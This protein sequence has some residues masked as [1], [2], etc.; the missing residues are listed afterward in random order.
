MAAIGAHARFN[1]FAFTTGGAVVRNQMFLRFAGEGT[2]ASI[3]GATLLQAAASTSTRRSSPITRLPDCS[4]REV[5]KTV[6]DDE[7]RG[8]FQ[9]KIIVRP[10]AQKTDAKMVTQA[11]LLSED[12]EADNKPE[13]EIFADDVQCG[14]GA[15]AG[16]LDEDLLFYLMARGIPEKEAEALLIQA[17]IGEAIEGI[18]HAGLREALMDSAAQWLAERE[19]DA[20]IRQSATALTTSSASARI[21]RSWRC[22][23]TASRWSISTTPP[24]R[25]SRRRCST[26]CMQAYTS[27]YANVHRGLHYLANAA[28]EGLR[29]RAREGA[30]LP[31]RARPE[32]IIFTRNATEAINLVAYTFGA[33][34]HQGGRRDRA[35]DHGAPFQ[36]R[37][38]AFPARAPRRRDQVG[39]GRRRRQFPARRIREAADRRAP[40][41][42][43][44][45]RCRTRSAPIVPV[46]E[47]TRIAHARGIPVLVD[48]AQGAV[49]LDVDVQD[50]DCDFYVITGHKLYGP[51]GIGVLYGK[52]DASRRDAAV[53]RRRRDDP[54]SVRRIASPTASRRTGSRPARRRSC[55]RSGSAP[56]STTCSRSARRAS[57]RTRMT[58]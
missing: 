35:L 33:R 47:V 20:C 56:R 5:F 57:A 51:T 10:Q 48:G 52:Y 16:A 58:S 46:K 24:R 53:Q 28:T 22:R 34:A 2:V 43:R 55:R 21:S 40:R 36:H 45:R 7:S 44:S 19:A 13:L 18:E 39:A 29:G 30:G 15:T 27:E 25:R 8:I 4:S 41:W 49:H 50:I 17:F 9:G 3:R 54:R 1:S 32:E 42:S 31:Q 38:V 37:A 12:A 6:L 23:S 11:L 14:H 26:G